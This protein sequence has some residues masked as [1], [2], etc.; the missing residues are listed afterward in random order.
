MMAFRWSTLILA[1]LLTA[2][3]QKAF[4]NWDPGK[5]PDAQKILN[6]AVADARA[7]RYANA[8]EKH[9][10]FHENALKYAPAMYGVRLSFALSY[11][12]Q[13]GGKYPPALE[14]LREIRDATEAGFRTSTEQS[15]STDSLRHQFDDFESINRE[16][17]ETAKTTEMFTWLDSSHPG[18][19]A[20]TYDM[21]E[22][23]LIQ[24]KAYK[25]AGKYLDPDKALAK[26]IRH[27]DATLRAMGAFSGNSSRIDDL[28]RMG[29]GLFAR[30]VGRIVALLTVNERGDE[31]ARISA[32]ARKASH[33]DQLDQ[34]LA[35]ALKGE[36]P[37]WP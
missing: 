4:A 31:A 20:A 25:L 19:A 37:Q 26:A 3:S 29:E 22:P 16:L 15:Q 30:S 12:V 35:K 5:N 11:W 24:S 13:L 34:E 36:F 7:G 32:E 8:L 6:E 21:A 33:D 10:W 18:V 14:K 17:G 28:K 27:R 9:V 23:A 1:F 2:T